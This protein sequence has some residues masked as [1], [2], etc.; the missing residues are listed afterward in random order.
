MALA[1]VLR[2]PR[3]TTALIG[4]SKVAQ[5]ENN[6]AALENLKFAPE[7]LARIEGILAN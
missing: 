6:L 4:A 3:V 5:L 7:E 2:D 1:W